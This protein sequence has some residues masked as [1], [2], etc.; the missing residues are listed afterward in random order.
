MSCPRQAE[1]TMSVQREN[2]HAWQTDRWDSARD[3]ATVWPDGHDKPRTCSYCGGVHPDDAIALIRAGW[4]VEATTKGY[5]RYLHP[6]GYGADT[7]AVLAALRAG[8]LPPQ[9]AVSS[10]VPP[11]KLYTYHFDKPQADAFNVALRK[12][13][14]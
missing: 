7:E 14:A 8:A 6:P 12:Q 5:K 11:V 13:P 9:R 2:V 4:E 10:P 1:A 3:G